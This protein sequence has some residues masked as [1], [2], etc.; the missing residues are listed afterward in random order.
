MSTH[1]DGPQDQPSGGRDASVHPGQEG[2]ES[3]EYWD[4]VARDNAAWYIATS[5]TEESDEFFAQGARET[6]ALLAFCEVVVTKDDAVLEIGC[7]VGRM[8]RRLCELGR[9]VTGVDVSSVMIERARA[10]LRDVHNVSLEVISGNGDIPLPSS[11]ITV[12]FSYVTL[13][14]IPSRE[15]QLRY[16]EEAAR[17]LGPGGRLA[18]Q[19]RSSQLSSRTL[20]WAGHVLHRLT[21]R[22]T[23]SRAWRGKVLRRR[24]VEDVLSRAGMDATFK[25][26]GTRHVWV[27]ATAPAA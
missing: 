16:F 11:S 26:Q 4:D 22:H 27:I 15:W 6:D 9:H 2:A 8:T 24:D 5:F 13:Q 23:F 25:Q 12:V 10:N 19:I 3:R 21:G 18:I 1:A 17:V 7:G 14:H 20:N